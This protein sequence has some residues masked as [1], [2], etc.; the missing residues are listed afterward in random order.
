MRLAFDPWVGKIP[1]GGLGDPLQYFCLEESM[2]RS[3]WR[4]TVH[5]VTVRHNF[6]TKLQHI[7]FT[8]EHSRCS[9]AFQ[10]FRIKHL[11]TF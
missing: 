7:L 9:L 4:A 3:T 6:V 8:L 2:D 5:A 1:T 10:N 11:C